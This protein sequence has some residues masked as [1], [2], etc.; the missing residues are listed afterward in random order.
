MAKKDCFFR[1]RLREIQDFYFRDLK[2]IP[3]VS[4][5]FLAKRWKRRVIYLPSAVHGSIVLFRFVANHFDIIH[6]R[7]INC[8]SHY[9]GQPCALPLIA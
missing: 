9:L 1:F 7:Q 6:V 8:L 3:G 2:M 5:L 4:L